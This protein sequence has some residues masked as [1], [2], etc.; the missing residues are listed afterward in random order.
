METLLKDPSNQNVIKGI[1]VKG[2]A[3]HL[4]NAISDPNS[5]PIAIPAR[6]VV[7]LSIPQVRLAAKRPPKMHISK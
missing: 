5:V 4:I 1:T 7:N 2:S 3:I 6:T